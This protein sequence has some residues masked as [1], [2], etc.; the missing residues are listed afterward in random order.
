MP[1]KITRHVTN[2]TNAEISVSDIHKTI[3]D[4][5]TKVE[6]KCT[7][8]TR[9][10]VQK[11]YHFDITLARLIK[12]LEETDGANQT[13]F[14]VHLSLNLPS[15]LDCNNKISLE[16]YLSIV[17]SAISNDGEKESL[18]NEGDYVL[19]EGFSDTPNWQGGTCCVQGN[20]LK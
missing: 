18:L 19:V 7:D 6:L 9:N 12:V 17:V 3:N 16:N 2:N 5:I 8:P 13:D 11:H 1:T 15:Q 10:P 4:F 20:P 14:R